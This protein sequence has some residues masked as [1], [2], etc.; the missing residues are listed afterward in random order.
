MRQVSVIVLKKVKHEGHFFQAL[1]SPF[2]FSDVTY[3]CVYVCM[4]VCVYIYTY[5]QRFHFNMKYTFL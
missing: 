3:V 2:T 4:C 5:M 1:S